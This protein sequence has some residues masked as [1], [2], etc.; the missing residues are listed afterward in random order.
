FSRQPHHIIEA[1]SVPFSIMHTGPHPAAPSR[2]E[3]EKGGSHDRRANRPQN[4]DPLSAERVTVG[5]PQLKQR[6]A[7]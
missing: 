6:T 5:P 3:N 7:P 2:S 1:V 4:H